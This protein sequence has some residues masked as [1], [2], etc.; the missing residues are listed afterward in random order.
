VYSACIQR[1]R[2]A[3]TTVPTFINYGVTAKFC[4]FTYTLSLYLFTY[5]ILYL[6]YLTVANKQLS[7]ASL[8][9]YITNLLINFNKHKEIR[10]FY[11]INLG[12]Y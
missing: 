5:E 1:V 6:L 3:Y 11:I 12:R 8:V 4:D 7:S 10:T 9:T 2:T